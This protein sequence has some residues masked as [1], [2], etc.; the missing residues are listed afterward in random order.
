M[1]YQQNLYS[2]TPITDFYLDLAKFPSVNELARRIS[3]QKTTLVSHTVTPRQ[4]YRPDLLSYDLYGSSTL[5]W[6]IVLLNRNILKDPIRDLIAGTR[7]T[8]IPSSSISG[9]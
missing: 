2:R 4:Q 6:S 3:S 8:V 9:I 7:L 1:A 5:W